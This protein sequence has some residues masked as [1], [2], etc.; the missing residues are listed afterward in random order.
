MVMLGLGVVFYGN[1]LIGIVL[2]AVLFIRIILVK[3]PTI[4]V[5][6]LVAGTL[7]AG[8][9]LI[10]HLQLDRHQ[11]QFQPET[12]VTWTVKLY[13]DTLKV[14]GASLS[15]IGRPD[16]QQQKYVFYCRLKS[17][18]QQEL[19]Q[20]SIKPINAKMSGKLDHFLPTTN[21][22]QFDMNRYYH[23]QKIQKAF[24]A[25]NLTIM[26]PPVHLSL[27][28]RIHM[29][30]SRFNQYCDHLPKTLSLYATGLIS[31]YRPT[32]F[33][34]EMAGVKQLGLLHVFSISGMHVAYFLTIVDQLLAILELSRFKKA[35]ISITLLGGYFIF[36][37]GSPGLLRAVM[38]AIIAI[39]NRLFRINLSKLDIWSLSLMLNL[40]ILP[41]AMFLMGVQLSYLLA[42]G[43]IVSEKLT[44]FKQTILLNLLTVPILLFHIYEWHFLSV[45]VNLIVLPLF[46]KVIFPLVI[47]GVIVGMF[48][49]WLVT[50]V[51]W[52]LHL[53]NDSLNWISGLP[54][55][56]VFGKPAFWIV[57]MMLILTFLLVIVSRRAVKYVAL[58]LACLYVGT[59]M[60]IHFPLHGEVTMFDIGQGDS[61]LI[62]EPFNQ[63]ITIIDTGG[64]VHFNSQP[65][66]KE[67]RDYQ[68]KRL[69][70]NYLKSIGV[71]RIDNMCVSHQDA[72]HCGDLPAF[73]EEMNVRRILIPLGMDKNPGFMNRISNRK[74]STKLICVNDEMRVPGLPATIYHPYL[75]GKGENH[76][77]M[78][79][80]TRKG[81]LNWV[82]TG[83]LDRPGELDTLARH[84]NLTA[85][86]LKVGHHGSKT[87][88]DPKFISQLHPKIAL[89]S[90]GR[91]NRYHHPN[92]ETV[93]LL[94]QHNIKMFNTQNQGMVRYVYRH[95]VG[96]FETVL[97][98][99]E[100]NGS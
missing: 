16:G 42:L 64:K 28:D 22:N 82:F 1:R 11:H 27:I 98:G 59:F 3:N 97:S 17:K 56:I 86:V 8:V 12:P 94:K 40:M 100:G 57:L 89:I 33:F 26:G 30:R 74:Q 39:L 90:A 68:A 13:P 92:E 52:L 63:N 21:V 73:I 29:L 45:A 93:T 85:D 35:V 20:H 62:R 31:G 91:N 79:L 61:F 7:F 81:G 9:C 88:S 15:F 53:F 60:V 83:D 78:V 71:S 69:S 66:Q 48:S 2:L 76:D 32:H 23:H 67:S 54:G 96:H 37:G 55:L 58:G 18:G 49:L 41:E 50:P 84:P 10:T 34:D 24:I 87:S 80:A 44:Y 25:E 19:L 51:E 5:G 6:S 70:I 95:N 36:S 72:D 14:N 38:M 47:L 77:S 43:L 65:W 75:P 46:G 4:L 99:D